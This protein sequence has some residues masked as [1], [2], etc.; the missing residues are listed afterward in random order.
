MNDD[1]YL[2]L[3]GYR[4]SARAANPPMPGMGPLESAIM[5]T[6]WDAAGPLRGAEVAQRLEYQRELAYTTVMTVLTVLCRKGLAFRQRDS[7]AW[8]YAPALSRDAY[9]TEQVRQL[10]T[11]ARDPESVVRNALGEPRQ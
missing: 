10:V 5:L 8:R 6:L 2:P 7:R 1:R 3:H 11:L 4:S 9:L